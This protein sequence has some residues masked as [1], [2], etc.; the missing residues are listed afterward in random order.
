[1]DW[2]LSQGTRIAAQ[3]IAT[4]PIGQNIAYPKWN[5]SGALAQDFFY[6]R[7]LKNHLLRQYFNWIE[8]KY[9]MCSKHLGQLS[10]T[11][12]NSNMSLEWLH[13]GRDDV[14]DLQPNHCLLNRLFR[15]RSTK[16]SKLRITGLCVG[17]LPVTGEFPAQLTSNAKMF[18]FDDVIIL[19]YSFSVWVP[20]YHQCIIVAV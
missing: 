18:P 2:Q 11:H 12:R 4:C 6:I 5:I 3:T 20:I 9:Y 16:S 7:K 15:R 19:E 13:N 10:L 14:T 17:N 1:M 8:L